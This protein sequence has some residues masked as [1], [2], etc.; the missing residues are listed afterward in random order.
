MLQIDQLLGNLQQQQKTKSFYKKQLVKR[1]NK[2]AWRIQH[3]YRV[4]N[5]RLKI[6]VANSQ[7]K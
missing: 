2:Y 3:Y 7:N 4:R 5:K 6:N 1:V